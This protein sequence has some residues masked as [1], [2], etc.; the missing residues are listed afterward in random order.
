LP[1]LNRLLREAKVPE[2]QL[3]ADAHAEE[4]QVDEE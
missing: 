4:S 1:A 2:V 3:D